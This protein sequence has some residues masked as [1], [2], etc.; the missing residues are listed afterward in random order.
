MKT[1]W[2]YVNPSE[3]VG[4]VDHLKVFA[5][6]DAA[7]RWFAENIQKVSRFRMRRLNNKK[8]GSR[9]AT[10]LKSREAQT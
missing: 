10:G 8:S 9:E 3:Q 1:L 6:E 2:I 4:D 5:D 7:N